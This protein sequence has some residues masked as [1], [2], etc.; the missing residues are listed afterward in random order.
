MRAP[1]QPAETAP[2]VVAEDMPADYSADVRRTWHALIERAWIVPLC[3]VISLALGF[4]YLRRAPVLYSA[5]ATLQ[6]QQ[7]QAPVFKL[8][9]VQFQDL[10]ALD[11]LQTIAQTLKTRPLLA[12]VAESNHLAAD[13]RFFSAAIKAAAG[14]D[15][16]GVLDRLTTVKLRR[17]TRLIDVTVKHSN[18]QLT[19]LLANSLVNE[20]IGD[21]A[22]QHA[23]T[24]EV[25]NKT[26]DTEATRL[27]KK[28]QVSEAALQAYRETNSKASSLDDRQNTVVAAL[29]ELSTKVTE[30]KSARIKLESDYSQVLTL[31]NNPEA[32]VALPTIA[33]NASVL[34]AKQNLIKSE[35][36]FAGLKQ[37]Y[38]EK[39]PKYVQAQ[40]Q[41]AAL[42]NDLAESI[43]KAAQGP[44]ASLD[45]ARAS[46][47]ALESALQA[48]ETSA[49]DLNK[50]SI[51]YGV[52]SREVESDRALYESVLKTMK[53]TSV[54]KEIKP[55]R[56]RVVQPAFT[57]IKPFSPRRAM[58][59]ALSGLGGIFAGFLLVLCLNFLDSSIK[60][61][62]E[63]ETLLRLPVLA[64]VSDL[65][66][67]KR[68]KHSLVVQDDPQS[69]GAE[70]FRTLRTSLSM[71]GRVEDRRVFLFTSSMP[72]EGKTF[73]SLNYAA[74]L[75][76]LGL[77]V[78]LIDGDLR[79]PSVELVL[80]GKEMETAG[81]TD[82][83]TGRKSFE[84]VIQPCRLPGLFFI[85]GGTI[86][87]N[88]AE[89]LA[90]DGLG[91]LIERAL[92]TYD[93]VVLDSA[94]VH[95]VSDTLL[96]LKNVQTVCLIIRGARTSTRSVARCVHLL[97]GAQAP[98]SGLVLNRMPLRR[99]IGYGYYKYS[100]YYDYRYH[101]KYSKKGV[102]GA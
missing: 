22:E 75:A 45:A 101:G 44:K 66:E 51:Q 15:L 33:A 95:A 87:P 42:Q 77:K 32:L 100:P 39:H 99:G 59:A 37:R 2:Y 78:L 5:T 16:V 93:R 1:L 94:P 43:L 3:L 61:V 30:A 26:L 20:F 70:A 57:P 68:K 36:E 83:L 55:M 29:K 90:K 80:M 63:A 74:S 10:Q 97:K 84:E 52:L 76:Q 60:T 12:R 102:Y 21:N 8:D 69:S 64:T 98:L 58:I 18:P 14:E 79:K 9:N 56:I 28:L 35:S 27:R 7:D 53:E 73:C 92:K 41:L 72:A 82:Y 11:F 47:A 89:L 13:P 25:A 31:G 86:A 54:T 85:S 50:L 17:G 34:A 6:V 81:V 23:S 48:Q 67:V 49:L 19:D 88:P 71:L 96:M 40:T 4:A 38:K 24:S 62:D 91:E 46:E 65:K